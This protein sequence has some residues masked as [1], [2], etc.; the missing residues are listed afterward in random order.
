MSVQGYFSVEGVTPLTSLEAGAKIHIIGVCGVAMAQMAVLLSQMGFEVSGSDKEFYEPMGSLL[1]GSKIRLFQGYNTSNIPENVSLVVIGNAVSRDHPEVVEVQKRNLSYSMFPYLLYEL[2]IKG[3]HS[4][5][6]AGT[7]GKSTTTALMA[8]VLQKVGR[9]PGLFIGG[10]ANDFSTSL[11]RGEGN[12]SVVEGDEYDSSFFAKVPKFTFYRPN[13]LILTSIE[14]DHADIYSNLESVKAEFDKLVRSIGAKGKVVC[15]ID[16]VNIASLLPTWQS[17]A[18]CKIIT[19]G[20]SENADWR[21]CDCVQKESEQ[22][23]GVRHKTGMDFFFSVPMPGEYNA[24]NALA[25][26]IV[27]LESGV[28]ERDLMRALVSFGG[29][30]RRQE[31]KYRGDVVLIEDFAHHP[32]AVRE[33][34]QGIK[35]WFPGARLWAVFEPRSNT[36]RRKDFQDDYISAFAG[37]NR[38]VL[39]NVMARSNDFSQQLLDVNVLAERISESGIPA[40]CLPESNSVFE[41][42]KKEIK[43]GDVLLVMSNGSFGGLIGKLQ[44]ELSGNQR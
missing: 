38:V 31:V 23:V 17:E 30:K 11:I 19:Y 8:S 27:G 40:V 22:L 16:D 9:K 5:V 18:A 21:L 44:M 41:Y 28:G 14:F 33:T 37:A 26:F 2:V 3:K 20:K 4:I 35:K 13:T 43:K 7:H 24:L 29:V 15:C 36:S 32:T 34:I 10:I 12:F 25:V 6:I 42:L 1:K 39:C